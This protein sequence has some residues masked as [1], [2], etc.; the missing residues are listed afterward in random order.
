VYPGNGF[1]SIQSNSST[2]GITE[3]MIVSGNNTLQ[4]ATACLV[5]TTPCT[6][7]TGNWVMQMA[8][9]RDAS[10]TTLKGVG[11]LGTTSTP[12]AATVS[13]WNESTFFADAYCNTP[14]VLDQ[15]C[16]MNTVA[17]PS[18]PAN[19]GHIVTSCNTYLFFRQS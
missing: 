16:V 13:P 15:S 19:G 4:R 2:G 1:T 17:S 14:G 18:F 6:G 7:A 5:L 12:W 11:V 8:V 9:F 3:Q 10:I